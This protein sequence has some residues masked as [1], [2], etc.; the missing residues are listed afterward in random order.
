MTSRIEQRTTIIGGLTLIVV[1][2]VL[3]RA[4]GLIHAVPPGAMVG[5]LPW[6]WLLRRRCVYGRAAWRGVFTSKEHV[7]P[8]P[9]SHRFLIEVTVTLRPSSPEGLIVVITKT[10]RDLWQRVQLSR[11]AKGSLLSK[12]IRKILWAIGGVVAA[13]LVFLVQPDWDWSRGLIAG[14]LSARMHRQ[15]QITGP[16]RVR[17][18]SSTPRVTLA[19][20]KVAEPATGMTDAPKANFAEIAQLTAEPDIPPLLAGQLHLRRLEL[21]RPV[22]VMFQDAEGH[23]NW[24]FS[25]GKNPQGASKL[26]PARTLIVMDGFASVTMVKR[27]L[28]LTGKATGD[29]ASGFRFKGTGTQDGK[30]CTVEVTGPQLGNGGPYP[31][32]IRLI[33]GPTRILAN[34]RFLHPF[35]FG[36]LAVDMHLQG[37]SL[38]DLY[39][40]LS[41]TAPNTP[42]FDL[43]VHVDRNEKLYRVSAITGHVGGSDLSGAMTIDRRGKRSM[44]TADFSSRVLDV[45]GLGS[46]F[47]ATSA[48]YPLKPRMTMIPGAAAPARSLMPDA[49]L[50]VDRLRSG[51]ADIHYRARSMKAGPG[52]PLRDVSFTATLRQGDLRFD[53]IVIG[54]TKGE[55]KGTVTIDARG[56]IQRETVDVRISGVRLEDFG[57]D[58]VSPPLAGALAVRIRAEATGRSV[59]AAA[60][61]ANG[62]VHIVI[63]GG[64]I[65]QSLAEAMGINASKSLFLALAKDPHRADI[66]CGVADFH[67]HD[68]VMQAQRI[69]LDTDVVLVNGAGSIDLR[70]ERINLSLR[71]KPKK[72]RLIRIDAPIVI[73]G[74][75]TQPTFGIAPAPAVT[76]GGIAAVVGSVLPF[77]TLDYAKDVDCRAL[78]GA[79]R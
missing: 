16:I 61:T 32:Q 74:H 13:L 5:A 43:S 67:L 18:L 2:G 73:G 79:R 76:Q 29:V 49:R 1:A 65:R 75:L 52:M 66:R 8:S 54:L 36:Q 44:L 28:S 71:G 53:P 41:V 15:V 23:S 48:N 25:N 24:D 59:H 57:K 56:P 6:S 26:P 20:V 46:I 63:P 3:A 7:K 47:G 68:G 42:A 21:D 19:G 17:A 72:F 31:F 39:Y 12:N 40:L 22:I 34:G 64:Q 14:F 30:P 10:L 38:S 33:S 9:F 78:E 77:I 55:A 27:R 62:D 11:P 37:A 45:A 58:K 69:I 50:D 60:S 35:D 51:D 70:D 4:F